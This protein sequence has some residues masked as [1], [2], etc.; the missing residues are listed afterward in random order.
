[1]SQ[2]PNCMKELPVNLSM[3]QANDA[4]CGRVEALEIERERLKEVLKGLVKA[5]AN[6]V[7]YDDAACFVSWCQ[8]NF[9]AAL[10]EI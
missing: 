6:A 4:L 7:E 1:M 9:E 5:Y 3:S 8:D 10:K 2:C